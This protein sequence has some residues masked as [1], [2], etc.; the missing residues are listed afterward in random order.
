MTL[1]NL[2]I[3][4][5]ATVRPVT[6]EERD[7]YAKGNGFALIIDDLVHSYIPNDGSIAVSDAFADNSPFD[8][9]EWFTNGEVTKV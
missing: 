1:Y 7:R 8:S 3:E 6:D 4:V 5:E 9:D 2:S